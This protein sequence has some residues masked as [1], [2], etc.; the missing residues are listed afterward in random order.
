MAGRVFISYRRVDTPHVAGRLFDRLEIRFGTGNVFMD[1]DSIEPGLDFAETIEAAVGASDV[2]LAL[3]GPRWVDA[4]DE[5]GRRRLED[6]DDFI[7]L[8]ITAALRRR[9][10]VIPVLVDGAPPPRREDLPESLATLA[11]RQGVRLD[12]ASFGAGT[13]TLMSALDRAIRA[14]STDVDNKPK[15]ATTVPHSAEDLRRSAHESSELTASVGH[16]ADIVPAARPDTSGMVGPKRS[17]TP[18]GGSGETQRGGSSG[19][20]QHSSQWVER[21]RAQQAERERAERAT[22][23]RAEQARGNAP[24]RRESQRERDEQAERERA[25]REQSQQASTEGVQPKHAAGSAPAATPMSP[26]LRAPQVSRA[27]Q[28]EQERLPRSVSGIARPQVVA[29]SIRPVRRIVLS[30]VAVLVLVTAASAMS[31]LWVMQQFYVGVDGNQVTIFQG[32]RGEVLGV[33]LHEVVE[34]TDV[35]VDQLTE[36]DRNAVTDGIIAPDGLDGAHLLVQRL[37]DR[38]LP[39]CPVISATTAPVA[40]PPAP[41]PGQT[42]PPLPAP[43]TANTTPLPQATAIPGVTCRES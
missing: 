2:L 15:P 19:S 12:H 43:T 26:W 38:M 8:E 23:E 30:V 34:H 5:Y 36:T 10:R 6:P 20:V 9:I 14:Q 37:Y 22:R 35:T 41:A 40:P 4:V 29:T 24:N 42:P 18:G 1:V 16:P 3:I 7:T 13:A 28:V 17:D 11:R 25:Q 21:E 33:P 31:R 39:P 32:V 27:D